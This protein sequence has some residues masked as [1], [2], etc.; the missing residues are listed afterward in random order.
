MSH[1]SSYKEGLSPSE[2]ERYSR[3]IRLPQLGES[4]Q[5]RLKKSAALIVGCGGLGSPAALY[6]AAAGVGRLTLVD[7]DRVELSNLHR[8]VL[9]SS[10]ALGASKA[11]AAAERL[12]ALNPEIDIRSLETRVGPENAVFLVSE[13]D[14]V[15][16]GS[17]NYSTRYPV[18]DACARARR[19]LVFGSIDRFAAQVSVFSAGEGPCYRCLYP[20]PPPLGFHGNCAEAGVLGA[21]P[22]IVGA[23]QATEAIKILL[24]LKGTLS[25]RLLRVD[26]LSMRFDEIAVPCDPRCAN[27]GAGAPRENQ[28]EHRMTERESQPVEISPSELKD[29][30]S[31]GE[32]LFLLDVREPKEFALAS[33]GG[34]LIPLR[35]LPN[36]A[37]EIDAAL[38]IVT[39]CHH[40][41][42]S[43]SAAQWLRA[44]GFPTARSLSGGIDRWSEEID[45][46]VPRY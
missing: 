39:I 25:G 10:N 35:E 19:P 17:D 1:D 27:C 36:R 41:V 6:L 32:P 45:P 4:G 12:R 38:P 13:H 11:S 40:G 7:F 23:I 42:R 24:G 14:V 8:Q 26:A 31:K 46:E 30:L 15:L 20:E 33:M 2:R 44:N 5:E 43:Y 29:S 18:A 16:D 21:L 37:Q 3:Q 22:G 28:K 34:T 9:F